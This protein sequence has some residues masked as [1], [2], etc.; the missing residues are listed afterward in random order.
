MA[1]NKKIE[2][3]KKAVSVFSGYYLLKKLTGSA[4]NAAANAVA[5]TELMDSSS[6]TDPTSRAILADIHKG[7]GLGDGVKSR[8]AVY[9][10]IKKQ[11]F[12]GDSFDACLNDAYTQDEI[13]LLIEN[14]ALIR[15]IQSFGA[16]L[17]AMSAVFMA[18]Y[19]KSIL[20]L[21]SLFPS[22]LLFTFALRR[23]CFEFSLEARYPA[24]LNDL[25]SKSRDGFLSVWKNRVTPLSLERVANND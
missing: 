3:A 18:V 13:R 16:I 20:P 5:V 9:S 6:V 24:N 1:E 21:F 7:E 22:V 23:A 17:V 11:I 8:F 19:L 15:M 10:H 14:S 4:K 12:H 25:L 2:L